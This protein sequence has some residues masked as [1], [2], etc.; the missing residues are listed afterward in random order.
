MIENNR[1]KI[2][3]LVVELLE[4]FSAKELKGLQ[5]IVSCT[6]FNTDRYVLKLLEVLVKK[7]IH[8]TDINQLIQLRLYNKVF[9]DLPAA[10]KELKQKQKAILRS[11]ISSLTRLAERFITI[12]ALEKS[13][14]HN[15]DL[16][17]NALIEKKQYRLFLKNLRKVE[18]ISEDKQDDFDL[19]YKIEEQR[20]NYLA[21]SGEWLKQDNLNEV[22][23][24]LDLRYLS[25][26]LWNTA[27]ALAFQTRKPQHNYDFS[28]LQLIDNEVFA[29]Y[30]NGDFPL[31]SLQL[32]S[33]QLSLKQTNNAFTHFINLLRQSENL[34]SKEVLEGYYTIALNFCI[35]MIKKGKTK[36]HRSIVN[37][38]EEMDKKNL[39]ATNV[40]FLERIRSIVVHGC[41]ANEYNWVLQK[42]KKYSPYIKEN[43]RVDVEN[44]NLGYLA[45]QQ[46]N[47][48]EAINYLLEVNN[49][50]KSYDIDKR[51][52]T[53]K[54][55]YELEKHY[56]EPTAQLF[57]SIEAFVLNNKQYTEVDRKVYKNTIRIFYNVYRYKHGV[58]KIA[59]DKLK[60]QVEEAEYIGSKTWLIKK[61]EE[62]RK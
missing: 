38:Y 33:I 41:R 11:K 1:E 48:Q 34:I 62:L 24:S 7:V 58:G 55:Y 17:L 32:A 28:I 50:Q 47:Y 14:I 19:K 61:I 20:L 52:L 21:K 6:Y 26:K 29:K 22:M 13:D 35:R 27:N 59:L 56:T 45:F 23:R 37:L 9:S 51:M 15:Y 60:Q 57:R 39:L 25:T 49:F 36:F 43:Y 44:F 40:S 5:K 2:P 4:S 3:Y 10:K 46:N 53:L 31:L 54:S 16:K 18:N 8:Q 42:I 12:E 30:L